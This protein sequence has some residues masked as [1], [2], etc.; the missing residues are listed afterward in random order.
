MLSQKNKQFINH[1]DANLIDGK[2]E[3]FYDQK[4]VYG[5]VRIK[6]NKDKFEKIVS[7]DDL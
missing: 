1:I 7:D 4:Y 6:I 3:I 5:S 2:S